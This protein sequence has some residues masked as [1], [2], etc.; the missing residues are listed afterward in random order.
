[1]LTLTHGQTA[2][3][4]VV[5]LKEK[6]TISN[7]T[8]VFTATNATTKEVVSF[9]LGTDLSSYKDRFNE[10]S[11]NTSVRFLNKPAGQWLY[12]I[13]QKS[14]SLVLEVGK[15]TLNPATDFEFSGY[16]P[17]TTYNGYSG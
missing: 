12:E 10:F 13:K 16:E 6:Q 3:L 11:I 8:F 9:D 2:D 17:E 7:A 4:I 5:T 15:L 1:M 14:D